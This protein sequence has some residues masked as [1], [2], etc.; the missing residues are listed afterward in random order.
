M[1]REINMNK[2]FY[3]Q[4]SATFRFSKIRFRNKLLLDF[5]YCLGFSLPNYL[6]FTFKGFLEINIFL[7]NSSPKLVIMPS[8]QLHMVGSGK[9]PS[10]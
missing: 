5:I 6:S 3:W 10:D 9:Q 2:T 4:T 8:L 7:S 1:C